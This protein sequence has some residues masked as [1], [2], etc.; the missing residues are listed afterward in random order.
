VKGATFN[1]RG[2]RAVVEVERRSGGIIPH[3][4]VGGELVRGEA[5]VLAF[6]VNVGSRFEAGGK[7][8]CRSY[9]R[10]RKLIPGLPRE[11]AEAAVD[12][13]V[14]VPIDEG[15]AAAVR[16][17]RAAYDDV[18]SSQIAFERAAGLLI[19]VL[20]TSA[21]HGQLEPVVRDRM[22]RW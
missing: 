18:D 9:L 3:A 6:E 19:A 2:V 12:G 22:N 4:L 5:G 13:L 17:D 14:R 10:R 1:A 20:I 11:F 8:T 16:V 7:R 15:I 21:S